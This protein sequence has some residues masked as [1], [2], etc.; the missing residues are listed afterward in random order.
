MRT[1]IFLPFLFFISKTKTNFLAVFSGLFQV[2]SKQSTIWI[3]GLYKTVVHHVNN[4]IIFKLKQPLGVS[5]LTSITLQFPSKR[6]ENLCFCLLHLEFKLHLFSWNENGNKTN[7]WCLKRFHYT[8][9]RQTS[10]SFNHFILFS[11]LFFL[12]CCLRLITT[13]RGIWRR[14][15]SSLA[16]RATW[17][18]PTPGW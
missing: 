5:S 9:L 17:V 18:W 11:K 7:I 13:L 2:C 16:P 10:Y 3:S 4:A 12:S 1:I 8:S 15:C 14:A 6:T